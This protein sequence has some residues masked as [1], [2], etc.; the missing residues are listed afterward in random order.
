MKNKIILLL[1]FSW[2]LFSCGNTSNE[3][4]KEQPEEA[5][6]EEHQHDETKTIEL[7][8]GEKWKVD[9]NMMLHIRN[10]EKNINNF[11]TQNKKIT[12]H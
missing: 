12:N 8:N 10:M 3:K 4:T 9:E 6:N 2:F 1:V 11:A 7:S 5:N